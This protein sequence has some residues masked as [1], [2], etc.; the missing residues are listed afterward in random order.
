MEK[1]DNVVLLIKQ[2]ISFETWQAHFCFEIK[3][4][5][6]TINFH[7]PRSITEEKVLSI[8]RNCISCVLKL[9]EIFVYD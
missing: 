9:N 2:C 1:H 4:N 8:L 7:L 3:K 5:A 6:W